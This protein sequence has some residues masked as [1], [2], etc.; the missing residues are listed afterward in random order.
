M[1][2]LDTGTW[3]GREERVRKKVD[4][5]GFVVHATR[6]GNIETCKGID[7]AEER[8]GTGRDG[9]L[10]GKERAERCVADTGGRAGKGVRRNDL[11][12]LIFCFIPRYQFDC[13]RLSVFFSL[14]ASGNFP[15]SQFLLFLFFFFR[16]FKHSLMVFCGTKLPPQQPLQSL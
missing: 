1:G 2:G 13:V 9:Y 3:Y 14:L 15:F 10:L 5:A 12:L 8:D 4:L 7:A 11:E 16:F 6:G